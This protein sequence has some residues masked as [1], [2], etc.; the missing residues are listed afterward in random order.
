[1]RCILGAVLLCSC[2][3]ANAAKQDA[4]EPGPRKQPAPGTLHSIIVRGNRLYSSTDIIKFSDLKI[5]QRVTGPIIEQAR[6]KL[7]STELFTNVSDTFRFVGNPP[8]YDLTIDVAE[9]DQLFPMRFER[10]G[11]S[12]SAV[13]QYLRDHVELYSDRIP[14]T[15]SVLKRYA[16]AVQEF[17]TK[18]DPSMK[19]KARVS[20]DDP[21]ELAVLFAPDTPPPTISQVIVTGNQAVDIGTILRAVN[22]VAI[23]IPLSDTRLKL[24]LDGAIRPLYAA[25][26]YAAV[27]FP[28]VETEPSKI[29]RGVVVKVQIKDGPVFKFGA[30]RFHGS[31]IDQ[32]EIRSSIPFKPGQPFNGQ[33]IDVFRLDLVHRMKR[34]GLL[35]ASVTTETQPD[36]TKRVVDVTYNVSAG[37]VYSF[38]KL[39]IQGL[40]IAT[41]PVVARLWGEK[42]GKPFNPDYPDF[43][44]KRVQ[45]QGLFDNLADTRSEYTADGASHGVTVHLYFKGGQSKQDKEKEKKAEEERRQGGDGTW[46]PYPQ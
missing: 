42:P 45:E 41:E 22:Q 19:V 7:Q 36:D 3:L 16:A 24:I 13:Q 29:N 9:I 31:G 26:G 20:N 10:L 32:E 38:Q 11:V 5:G 44:L 25:K 17:V 30:L 1:M 6:T 35:D 37:A 46:S 28:K 34:R 12:S 43:F 39:D 2:A 18:T 14:G 27:T 15:E 23:G 8:D 33:Q 4:R 21:K 40:D